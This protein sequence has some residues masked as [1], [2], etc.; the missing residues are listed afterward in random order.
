MTRPLHQKHRLKNMTVTST[1]TPWADCL[2]KIWFSVGS[3][4]SF[5]GS[6]TRHVRDRVKNDLSIEVCVAVD[7]THASVCVNRFICC[8]RTHYLLQEKNDF[9]A[10]A[11][12]PCEWAFKIFFCVFTIRWQTLVKY[13]PWNHVFVTYIAR[14]KK[15]T[16]SLE[17]L[18]IHVRVKQ[19]NEEALKHHSK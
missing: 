2:K 1:V 13:K 10:D 5:E 19:N 3:L 9:V 6:F 17:I 18:Y 11:V 12:A 16:L 8:H 7:V 14:L 15:K 4:L